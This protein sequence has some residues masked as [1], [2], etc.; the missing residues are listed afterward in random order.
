[1]AEGMAC[2][3][4]TALR[5]GASWPKLCRSIGV[6]CSGRPVGCGIAVGENGLKGGAAVAVPKLP[7]LLAD[8]AAARR[9]TF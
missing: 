2:A 4:G 5:G 1:M 8:Q 3:A 7:G 9:V 6:S